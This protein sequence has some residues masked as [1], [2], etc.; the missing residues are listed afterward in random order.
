MSIFRNT[1]TP[2][3]KGQLK[4]RQNAVQRRNPNDI[5]YQNSRNSWVRMT[6]GVNVGGKDTLA[7]QYILQGGVL[8][9]KKLREGVG[10]ASSAYSNYAPSLNPYNT[11]GTAGLKPMPGITSVDVKSKTAYGSLRE[12]TVNFLCHNIQQLEDLELLYMRPGYTVL[13]EWGWTPYLDNAGNI[14]SN[15]SFYDGAL[16]GKASNGKNDGWKPEVNCDADAK[17]SIYSR[18]GE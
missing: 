17:V 8:N 14:Q 18:W 11:G 4:A 7:K 3:V 2:E 9:N 16:D 12:V 1:F 5:I 13:V 15:I 6:S 10:D